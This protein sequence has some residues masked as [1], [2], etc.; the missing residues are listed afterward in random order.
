[1]NYKEAAQKII[2]WFET[3]Q[4]P[5]PP[6]WLNRYSKIIDVKVYVGHQIAVLK[7]YS[8]RP[9]AKPFKPA[10]MR[11]YELKKHIERNE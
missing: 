9:W 11:L 5:E 2:D 8:D 6:I 3:N 7:H 1:M 4:L 10:Y